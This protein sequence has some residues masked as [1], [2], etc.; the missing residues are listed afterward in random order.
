MRRAR[1]ARRPLRRYSMSQARRLLAIES[2]SVASVSSVISLLACMR[3]ATL[4]PL[5][6]TC[7][8]VGYAYASCRSKHGAAGRVVLEYALRMVSGVIHRLA[9]STLV[10]VFADFVAVAVRVVQSSFEC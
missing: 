6:T 4:A 5:D 10:S 2:R 7:S 3:P 9:C 1:L 8:F